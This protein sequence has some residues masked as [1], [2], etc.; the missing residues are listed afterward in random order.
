MDVDGSTKPVAGKAYEMATVGTILAGVPVN[1]ATTFVKPAVV[2][3]LFR[4]V[5]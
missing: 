3:A 1:A 5:T 4:A 2:N